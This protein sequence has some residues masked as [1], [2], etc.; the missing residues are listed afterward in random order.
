MTKNH[1]LCCE[2]I[3]LQL[4]QIYENQHVSTKNIIFVF[5]TYIEQN[6]LCIGTT[7]LKLNK[8]LKSF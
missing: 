8:N 7:E 4:Q 6:N 5:C 2:K 3:K 1:E